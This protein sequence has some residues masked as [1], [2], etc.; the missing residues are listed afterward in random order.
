MQHL[1]EKGISLFNIAKAE[2]GWGPETFKRSR[3]IGRK[4]SE[5]VRKTLADPKVKSKMR[6]AKLGVP[7]T[8]Q[9]KAKISEKLSGITKS[10]ET[11]ALM[12]EAQKRRALEN[13]SVRDTMSQIGKMNRGKVPAN[14]V[15]FVVNGATYPSGKAAERALGITSRQLAAKVK[16]GTAKR[17]KEAKELQS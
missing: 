2:G 5:S 11:R 6:A 13:S 1:R 17:T 3:E 12:S 9:E 10:P 14:A 4:I 7:R 8:V 15:T 16:D